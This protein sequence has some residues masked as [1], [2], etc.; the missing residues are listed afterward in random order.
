MPSKRKALASE[1]L[2]TLKGGSFVTYTISLERA[3][4]AIYV[5]LTEILSASKGNLVQAQ[6][7]VVDFN[8]F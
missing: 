8:L 7:M 1:D 4:H 5:E 2:Q 3:S 6:E